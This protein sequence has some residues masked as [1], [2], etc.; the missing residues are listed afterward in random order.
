[1]KTNRYLNLAI[2]GLVI[3]GCSFTPVK[4]TK[5]TKYIINYNVPP[6]NCSSNSNKSIYI[7]NTTATPPYD[8]HNMLYSESPYVINQYS[9]SIWANLPQNTVLRAITQEI[10]NTCEFSNVYISEMTFATDYVLNSQIVIIKENIENKSASAELAIEVQ[11]INNNTHNIKSNLFVEKNT[12]T[13]SPQN[14]AIGISN[15]L[16]NITHEISNWI[17]LQTKH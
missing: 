2:I 7:Q 9:Y 12:I 5:T 13:P 6:K 11:L 3:C 16:I 8:T 17:L 4:P 10:Q 15:D 14:F 1:M